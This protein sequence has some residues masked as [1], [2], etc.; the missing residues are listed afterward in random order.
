M[1]NK[2][3]VVFALIFFQ[4]NVYSNTASKYRQE[5]AHT[6][7]EFKANLPSEFTT[8]WCADDKRKDFG[9]M[10]ADVVHAMAVAAFHEKR[11]D[12]RMAGL[13][14]LEKYD[15]KDKVE[16]KEFH[17]LLDWGIKSGHPQRY[18]KSLADRA[19][20]LREKVSKKLETLN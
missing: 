14:M 1:K 7:R 13:I 16:C 19:M 18:N 5:C 9:D 17:Y 4:A 2:I 3:V 11:M 15:C 12:R 10:G 20:A 6:S 8:V